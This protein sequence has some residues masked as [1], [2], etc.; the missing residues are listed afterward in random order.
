MSD[1]LKLANSAKR[2]KERKIFIERERERERDSS[3]GYQIV[4]KMQSVIPLSIPKHTST[5]QLCV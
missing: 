2:C 1:Y 5:V 3:I 4:I